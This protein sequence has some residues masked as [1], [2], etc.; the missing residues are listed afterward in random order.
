MEFNSQLHL[1]EIKRFSVLS[2]LVSLLP[3][4]KS[5]FSTLN[6]DYSF[7]KK[8]RDSDVPLSI[9]VCKD[10]QGKLS[11]VCSMNFDITDWHSYDNKHNIC[12]R[13]SDKFELLID[14][15]SYN[16]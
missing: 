10:K 5:V 4:C 11:S 8:C 15:H 12:F 2:F 14:G 1:D 13:K 3:D 7:S 6:H 9:S 16:V